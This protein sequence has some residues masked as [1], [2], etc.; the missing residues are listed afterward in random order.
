M[1]T[2][3]RRRGL[4]PVRLARG[5]EVRAAMRYTGAL[6]ALADA[7]KHC[8]PSRRIA[9]LNAMPD[10]LHSDFTAATAARPSSNQSSN[11]P[12]GKSA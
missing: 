8:P 7:L 10:D 11:Q 4:F 6:I 5:I 12:K 1:D 2:A 9:I 3:R